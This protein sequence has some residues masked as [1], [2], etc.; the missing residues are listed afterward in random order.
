[1]AERAVPTPHD[2]QEGR[3]LRAGALARPGWPQHLS[4]AALGVTPGAVSQC[5]PVAHARPRGGRGGAAPPDLAGRAAQADARAARRRARPPRPGRGGLRLPRRRVDGPARGVAHRGPRRGAVPPG[6]RQP[7]GARPRLDAAEAPP[8]G[9]PTRRGGH[10]AVVGRALA[11]AQKGA[12]RRGQTIVWVDESGFYLLPGR[13][14][15]YAPRG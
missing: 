10:P 9:N 2:W 13:V 4:A 14:R 3:R 1:M 6:P 8:A 7:A 11:A 5:Q 15:T 12:R